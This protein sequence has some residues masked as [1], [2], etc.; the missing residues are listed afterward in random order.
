MSGSLVVSQRVMI[1]VAFLAQITHK[2]RR[3]GFVMI[4]LH[5]SS[6]VGLVTEFFPTFCT[7]ESSIGFDHKVVNSFILFFSSHSHVPIPFISLAILSLIIILALKHLVIIKP[8]NSIVL[9][10]ACHLH[11]SHL[12]H[13]GHLYALFTLTDWNMQRLCLHYRY[14]DN[15]LYFILWWCLVYWMAWTLSL[16][17]WCSPM[18]LLRWW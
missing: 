5:M 18:F 11:A 4:V 10:N 17:C 13:A 7:N 12:H 6:T 14:G 9:L 3:I 16:R 1:F 8:F 2:S 15:L